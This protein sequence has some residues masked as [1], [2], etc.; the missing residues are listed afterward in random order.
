MKVQRVL[1]RASAGQA[2]KA[3]WQLPYIVEIGSGDQ[4]V[5]PSLELPGGLVPDGARG[6]LLVMAQLLQLLRPEEN[7]Q[8]LITM[9][10]LS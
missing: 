2:V 4:I 10:R 8:K 3:A 9:S 6:E 7:I 1:A 5:K